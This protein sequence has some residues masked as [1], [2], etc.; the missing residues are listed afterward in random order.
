MQA[1]IANGS[2]LRT[3]SIMGVERLLWRQ[4]EYFL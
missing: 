2:H 4:L 3:L 1:L